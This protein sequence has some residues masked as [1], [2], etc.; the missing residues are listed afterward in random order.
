MPPKKKS[1]KSQAKANAPK[2]KLDLTSPRCYL[3]NHDDLKPVLRERLGLLSEEDQQELISLVPACDQHHTTILSALE[4]NPVFWESL[5]EWLILLRSG[6]LKPPKKVL[7]DEDLKNIP[8]KD[9]QFESYW[10]E[11]EEQKNQQ[12]PK[13]RT[14][15]TTVPSDIVESDLS[16][17]RK[18]RGR[19]PKNQVT[20]NED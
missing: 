19:A 14:R 13:R 11:L 10:G 7:D 8:W 5:D 17:T 3:T 1:A 20:K 12:K 6:Y 2:R 15:S 4:E 16:T 18:R 9:E